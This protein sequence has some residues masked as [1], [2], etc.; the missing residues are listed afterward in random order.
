MYYTAFH[1]LAAAV[2]FYH[3]CTLPKSLTI[4]EYLLAHIKKKRGKKVI[5]TQSLA[6]GAC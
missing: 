2:R 5:V 4:K 3:A 1:V 6:S